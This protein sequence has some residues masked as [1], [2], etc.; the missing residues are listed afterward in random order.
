M[1]D[2]KQ[3]K[4]SK[5]VIVPEFDMTTNPVVDI[6]TVVDIFELCEHIKTETPIVSIVN[7]RLLDLL[8]KN[9][10]VF[11]VH[12]VLMVGL[13]TGDYSPGFDRIVWELDRVSYDSMSVELA[14][15]EMVE[16]VK[17]EE[18]KRFGQKAFKPKE[19]K[20]ALELTPDDVDKLRIPRGIDIIGG[21]DD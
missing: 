10:D 17:S 18:K 21:G 13:P 19:Q 3:E 2:T 15:S 14:T 5:L 4:A 8:V 20:S 6:V 9:Q 16:T 7:I 11:G 1:S 12:L